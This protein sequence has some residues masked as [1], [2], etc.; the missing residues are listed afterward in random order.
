MQVT[1]DIDGEPGVPRRRAT[2]AARPLH[3]R[4][5]GLTARIGAATRPIAA[6]CVTWW[7]ARP[8]GVVHHARRDVRAT[9]PRYRRIALKPRTARSTRC[10][11]GVQDPARAPVRLLH[12]GHADCELAQPTGS[13][14]CETPRSR[15]PAI[16]AASATAPATRTSSA[17]IRWGRTWQEHRRR[18]QQEVSVHGQWRRNLPSP[19]EG[20]T[21][22]LRRPG[23]R[24]ETR[25]LHPRQGQLPRRT[26]AAGHGLR[27]RA[28]AG[29]FSQ[30]K[31]SSRW[32]PSLAFAHPRRRGGGDP[33]GP[34]EPLP[35]L[36]LNFDDLLRHAGRYCAATRCASRARRSRCILI[37]TDEYTAN[38][39]PATHATW[40]TANCPS[41]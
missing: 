16:S 25:P 19:T 38:D 6:P 32:T 22:R 37:A 20:A 7:T 14:N 34:W 24:K 3:P 33:T 28:G 15:R 26:C 36:G 12:A 35:H 11:P 31:A 29:A 17:A 2:H 13:T 9:M 30:A 27:R 8:R 10:G 1:I 23:S 39:A 5:A 40:S 4:H 18:R 41:W 21:D